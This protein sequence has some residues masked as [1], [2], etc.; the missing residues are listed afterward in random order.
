M[1]NPFATD[2]TLKYRNLF[3]IMKIKVVQQL[4]LLART[5]EGVGARPR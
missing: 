2:G 1:L 3:S 4:C 5:I